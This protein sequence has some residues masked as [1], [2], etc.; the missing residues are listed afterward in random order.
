MKYYTLLWD[1]R[2]FYGMWINEQ[3]YTVLGV[4]GKSGH[5]R[6]EEWR[7]IRLAVS[8]S[9]QPSINTHIQRTLISH[10]RENAGSLFCPNFRHSPERYKLILTRFLNKEKNVFC[11]VAAVFL[12]ELLPTFL[13]MYIIHRMFLLLLLLYGANDT[14]NLDVEL[15]LSR[16][17]VHR[18]RLME[19][20][21]IVAK[22]WLKR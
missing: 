4:F 7:V 20:S 6:M 16:I 22:L 8:C 15:I 10:G 19:C 17:Y 21:V 14:S 1:D 5:R 11:F 3:I 12:C 18:W 13:A 2:W 9:I